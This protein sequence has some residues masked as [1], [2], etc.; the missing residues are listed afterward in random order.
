MLQTRLSLLIAVSVLILIA[1]CSGGSEQAAETDTA[2]AT[3]ISG[4]IVGGL[5]VLTIDP[6]AKDQSFTIYRGDYVRVQTTA[7][8]TITISIPALE[9]EQRFPT[10]DDEK[11][12]FKVPDV[13]SFPFTM[14]QATGVIRAQQYAATGYREVSAKEAA[15]FIANV[16][17]LILDVRTSREFTSGHLEGATLLPVQVFQYKVSELTERR[18]DP[19]LVYCRTGNRSTVAAKVLV[20]KGF[21]NVVNLR[22]GIVEWNRAQ[23]PVVK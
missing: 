11:P 2:A 7:R 9:V 23:L 1:G 21:T 13:G 3:A 18:N 16:D 10:A 8:D 14:G 15:D 22:R 17:P 6:R 19:I 20:D 12:Y 5:R 4:E